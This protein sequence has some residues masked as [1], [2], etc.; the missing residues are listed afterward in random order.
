MTKAKQFRSMGQRDDSGVGDM[1]YR[2]LEVRSSSISIEGRSIEADVTTENP[3]MTPDFQ[4]MEMVPEILVTKGAV[5][6]ESR[7]VPFLDSHQRAS[8]ANQLGSA[9]D[10]GT[11]Y[12]KLTARLHF[13]A[14]ADG[15]FTKV[16]EGHVTDVSAGY[17]ILKKQYVPAGKTENIM[18]RAYTGPANVVTKWK[19]REVS[20]TP[21]GADDQCKMRGFDPFTFDVP[22]EQRNVVMLKE[23]RDWLVTRGMPATLDDEQ[24]QKWMVD[25]KERTLVETPKTTIAAPL[26]KR[27]EPAAQKP[28]ID[29]AELA[30]LVS[31][32]TRAAIAE[33]Q[34]RQLSFRSDVDGL[35]DLAGL[36]E[37]KESCR[38][39]TDIDSVRSHLLA[40]KA[41]GV[42]SI[43]YGV[44]IRQTGSGFDELHKDMG[45]ALTMRALQGATSN[46]AAI[47]KVFPADQRRK[48]ADRFKHASLLDMASDYVGAHGVDVR[49][50]SRTDIAIAALFG[51]DKI[52]VRA[53]GVPA[54]NVTGGFTN[55][56][57]DATNKA[58]MV[59]YTECPM[60]WRGPMRQAAS[61]P[62]F[63]NINRIRMGAV[64]NLPVWND[65]SNPIQ[66]SF[67]DTKEAYVVEARSLEIGFSYRLI[68][69]D[70]MDALSRIPAQ[71]GT[72]AARTVNA[73]AWAQWTSNPVLQSDN[74]ALFSAAT[75]AR[76]RA[77]LTTGALTPT[78]ANL[79][80][81]SNLMRQMRGENTPEGNES[82]DI[83][84]LIPRYLIG[85][86]ALATTINQ[87]VLSAYDPA[88][89]SF[90]VYN[91][92]TQLIPVIE[93]LLDAN[94]TTAWYLAADT[95]QIDTVEVTFLQGQEQPIT[96]QFMDERNLSQN[97][98]ILQTVGAKAMNH[99]GLQKFT[100]V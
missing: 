58:M 13:S 16:R 26:E 23:L 71:M 25:N 48:N 76:K 75:G 79:Q 50:L 49:S 32:A 45:S 80:T 65:N 70:D 51:L 94:S 10:I 68:V 56:T 41:K 77:N 38:S 87:L 47:D 24:A 36:P 63:K 72:A 61:A 44:S 86:S 69:N 39:M 22:E 62:D 11:K 55:L 29:Q 93:P 53:G 95:S 64:P 5:I 89:N 7:Q 83:L 19:L 18:G 81:G 88:A 100:G 27:E 43:G 35:C 40:E 20:L 67:A 30:K 37:L 17:Q 8:V 46:Q 99:R 98:T 59:G 42:Q 78:V 28:V 4:R 54:Y 74:V 3:V 91:T 96:R 34:K 6:P 84:N 85:P 2:S 15:E 97:F 33:E 21:I 52:G 90:M 12:N 66:G 60:T 9:R 31:E 57:L 14:A 1:S 82:S 92:A 73:V